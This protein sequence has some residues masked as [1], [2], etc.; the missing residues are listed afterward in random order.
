[1]RHT[2]HCFILIMVASVFLAG[3][4]TKQTNMQPAGE[5]S[6]PEAPPFDSAVTFTGTIPCNDCLQVDITL[7]IR[8]DGIYQ[9]RKTYL[10]DQSDASV[11][12]QMGKWR[13][14]AD[15]K[16]LILGKEI[17]LLK[18]Y[19]I[20][21]P[22]R[23]TFVGWEGSD[24]K[25]QIQYEL[26]R[27]TSPAPFDDVVK[28]RG[29]FGIN[30]GTATFKECASQVSFAVN[31]A[32]DYNAALQNYMNTPH[33]MNKAI[34]LSILGRL[35]KH[36]RE[37]LV[38]EQFRKF[39]P[40]SDCQGNKI[41]TSLTGTH[42]QVLEIQQQK[43]SEISDKMAHLLLK[44]D[45]TIEGFSGCNKISG[46]FLV[47]GDVLLI[48]RDLSS[49]KACPGGMEGENRLVAV[50]DDAESFRIEENILELIDQNDQVLARFMAGP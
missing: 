31:P 33:D 28:I 13:Y 4:S 1:M 9:L 25:S 7:N 22:N 26:T 16:F 42:W 8:P 17:G 2:L 30:K 6:A 23:L 47:K 41:K 18:T 10:S 37:E 49:R 44:R 36:D 43:W 12:S 38:I 21:S 39:Y 48:K 5:A 20:E 40:N 3:C 15:G 29:M 34:L 35:V 19:V 11:S 46:T 27:S 45:K 32:G 14:G 50:L 24:N